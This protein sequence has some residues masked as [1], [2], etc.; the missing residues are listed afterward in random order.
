MPVDRVPHAS[1]RSNP[2]PKGRY[3]IPQGLP[4]AYGVYELFDWSSTKN[5]TSPSPGS[6]SASNSTFQRHF[7]KR[8]AESPP[9]Q[10]WLDKQEF[11]NSPDIDSFSISTSSQ[12]PLLFAPTRSS[13]PA[14][15]GSSQV[16][17]QLL[18]PSPSPLKSKPKP[19]PVPRISESYTQQ[20]TARRN[21]LPIPASSAPRHSTRHANRSFDERYAEDSEVEVLGDPDE[22]AMDYPPN[23]HDYEDDESDAESAFNVAPSDSGRT[24]DSRYIDH[25]AEVKRYRNYYPGV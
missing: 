7:Q 11:H 19:K 16:P 21:S 2:L 14:K 12:K 3:S 18:S 6:S 15:H 13:T 8:K 20:D 24:R 5:A 1:H 25:S 10:S 4:P 23:G 9:M 22:E 17:L